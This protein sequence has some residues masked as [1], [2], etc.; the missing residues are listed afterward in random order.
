MALERLN[1]QTR[2]ILRK[3]GF[4]LPPTKGDNALATLKDVNYVID[5]INNLFPYRMYDFAVT[6][7]GTADPVMTKLSS[8]A[9]ECPGNCSSDCKL[10]DCTANCTN[11]RAGNFSAVMARTGVGVYTLTIGGDFL[12]G[13]DIVDAGIFFRPF[14]VVSTRV[15]VTKT[16]ATVY[17]IRTFENTTPTDALLNTVVA[18]KVY[19]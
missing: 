17:T 8:G 13:A 6:Q 2:N 10:C 18:L 16:S 1:V 19:F 7:T 4:T 11:E 14:P 3:F 5:A 9:T 12:G 15:T